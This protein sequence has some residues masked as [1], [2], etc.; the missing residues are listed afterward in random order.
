MLP[1][2]F[3]CMLGIM[4]GPKPKSVQPQIFKAT[5]VFPF[6]GKFNSK[7]FSDKGTLNNQAL[8]PHSLYSSSYQPSTFSVN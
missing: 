3:T 2:G 1:Q 6:L 4:R 7:G 5:P 8:K